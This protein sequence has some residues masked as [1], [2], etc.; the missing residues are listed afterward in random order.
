MKNAH[1]LIRRVPY[2]EPHHLQLE[3]SASNGILVGQTDIYCNASDLA[4]IG[5]ALKKFPRFV[6]DQ[7]K[8][9]YGSS[10][11]KDRNYR[12][13]VLRAYTVGSWGQCALQI[14]IDLNQ[15]EPDEGICQFSI[16]AE[17]ASLNRLGGLLIEF[18]QLRHRELLWIPNSDECDLF[19]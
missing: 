12:H 19:E 7:Y 18:G 5:R 1:L 9:E 10:D 3:I 13:F 17:P 16:E 14:S 8:H 2:E 4:E 11:P 6:G 15:Q